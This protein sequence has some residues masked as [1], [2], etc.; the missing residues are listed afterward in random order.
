MSG[1]I[2]SFLALLLFLMLCFSTVSAQVIQKDVEVVRIVQEGLPPE[3]HVDD[4]LL[5]GEFQLADGLSCFP[6][7]FTPG[8]APEP[9]PTIQVWAPGIEQLG[10]SSV[11]C[12]GLWF[13]NGK[14]WKPRMWIFVIWKI[15][16]PRANMRTA[17][18]FEQDLNLAL[19]VDWDL[20]QD[21]EKDEKVLATSLNIQRYIP[22]R[23]SELEL[24]Y[25]TCFRVP[26]VSKFTSHCG[27]IEFFKEKLWTRALL[28]FCDDDAS[29]NGQSVF[30]EAED[31]QVT[32]FEVIK[33]KK[34]GRH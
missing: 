5:G 32:Y 28:S 11:E 7:R 20:S 22:T 14:E 3:A 12:D 10:R 33:N 6:P 4:W 25:L 9:Y 17:D 16:I 8:P 27:G 31:Y 19:W 34:K 2:N 29:P 30:G 15:R 18:E 13:L 24:W 26:E 1:K 23:H 21:W